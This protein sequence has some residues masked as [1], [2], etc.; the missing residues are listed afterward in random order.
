MVTRITTLLALCCALTTTLFSQSFDSDFQPFV[1]RPGDI[2]ELV[3]LPDGRFIAAGSFTLANREERA[4]IARFLPDGSLDEGF[5]PTIR[6]SIT[7]MA[8]QPDG[9]AIIGGSYLD[10]DAPEGITILRLNTNGSLDNSF[11]AGFAPDGSFAEIEVESNGS[12]LVGGS[13]SQFDELAVQGVIRLSAN[14]SLQN[15]IP[16]N[17]PGVVFVSSLLVQNNGRFAVGGTYNGEAYLSYHENSGAPVAGFNF[18]INLPSTTN[19]LVGIR[20][21][22]QDS[23]GRIIFSTGTFLIRYAVGIL[24]PDG[25]FA[26]WNYVFGIPQ[27]IAVDNNDQIYVSGDYGGVSAVHPFDPATGL[28][29]YDGGIG[30]DGLI[31][32][33]VIHPS[34]GFIAAGP[35]SAFDGQAHLGI[36]RLNNSG[37]PIAGFNS[38]VERVGVV[39]SMVSSGSDKVYISGDFAM[40]GDTYSPN[41]ARLFLDNGEADPSFNNPGIS[42]R[43]EV[44]RINL[45][46]QGRV[47]A[48]GTNLDNA[49]SPHEAPLMRLLPSGA[50]DPT[51]QPNPA[52]YPIGRLAK[53]QPLDNGQL[54]VIGDFNVFDQGIAASK[55]A[56]YNANGSLVRSFSDRIQVATA[57]E[58]FR[59]ND[60]RILLGGRDIRYDGAASQ[61]IIRLDA[62]LNRD[63]SFQSPSDIICP[64][65]CRFKFTEQADGKLL[66]GGI[67]RTDPAQENPFRMVRIEANGA[68]DDSFQL[69]AAFSNNEPYIDGG[70]R[71]MLCLPDGRILTV[72]LFDSLG[73]APAPSMVLLEEDGSLADNLE[74]LTFERQFLFDALLLEDGGF[75][76]GGILADPSLPRQSGLARV[77]YEPLSTASIAGLIQT[78]A[79][80]PVDGVEIGIVGQ[81]SGNLLTGA[82]GQYEFSGPQP[83]SD[84]TV[85]PMLNTGHANGVSTFDLLL[86]N[87]HILGNNRFDSPYQI[88]AAD[89]NN[90]QTLTTLDLIS[91]QKLILG[92]IT[93]FPNNFSWRFVDA[94]YIFPNPMNPWQEAFPEMI[95]LSNLPATGVQDANFIAIKIGDVDGSAMQILQARQ[96]NR[97]FQLWAA[98]Q[99]VEAGA[100]VRAPVTAG[101]L[102]AIRAFQFT[103][104]FQPSALSLEG[105]SYGLLQEED[106]G[107]DFLDKGWITA[108]CYR[109]PE[110]ADPE[111]TLFTLTF[112]AHR[113][114][115]LSEWLNLGSDFT[116]AEAYDAN[117]QVYRPELSFT[118]APEKA[119]QLLENA[120]NPF[121]EATTIAFEMEKAGE[122]TLLIHSSN[123]HRLRQLSGWFDTG[124]QEIRL[125]GEGLPEGVLFYTLQTEGGTKTGKMVV[126][127]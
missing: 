37:A 8:L 72:G 111:T 96:S 93:E 75:L 7:A 64:G 91:I 43:N 113:A 35:F 106:L 115:N 23:Q 61:P 123:G 62:N 90:S 2:E 97:P 30:A 95:R 18:S 40:A 127:R 39:R 50:F 9:K 83:G 89:V 76:I 5:Q 44:R 63:F 99:E 87:Q 25:S 70:P 114:G 107:W 34:G 85:M 38:A 19:T 82:D 52:T 124:R 32:K 74:G 88:I 120:P 31:R 105:F 125:S 51:F 53:V 54:L 1:T 55:V 69:P 81:P 22:N 121:S 86:I 41:I 92:R 101:G 3:I 17:T 119:P 13:F 103:L 26:E 94:A 104:R 108:S 24:N 45:D 65:D 60:G 116:Q 21:L 42:Y 112:R 10:E 68:L 100:L 46:N 49:E 98:G 47:L 27:S 20:D 84:Y 126:R 78:P 48:A 28:S 80:I 117:G 57:T 102:E 66:V 109:L 110:N 11:Q 12:I 36:V 56:L 77:T 59:L 33:A 58:I 71:K 15:I 79:G 14:G 67:F 4:N 118:P 6:F 122:A 29:N 16:L 73:L